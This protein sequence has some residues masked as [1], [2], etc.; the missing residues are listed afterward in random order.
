MVTRRDYTREAV[1][2]AHSVLIEIMR[3]LGEYRNHIVVVGGLV[4]EFL[5]LERDEPYVGTMDVDL[6]LD[7][8]ELQEEGYKTIEELLRGRG[9]EQSSEQPFIFRRKVPAA[10]REV[11]VQVDLLAGEYEGTGDSHRTQKVQGV[12]ARKAR[13]CDLAFDSPME[14]IIEGQLPGGGKTSVTLRVASIV[15]FLVMKG[16]ALDDRL[17]EKDAYDIYYCVRNF[18]KGLDGLVD[19]FNFYVD[20]D[21]V[22]EGLVKIKNHFASV[23]HDGPRFV[24]DFLAIV[25]SEERARV[26]RDAY[27]IVHYLLRELGM[28]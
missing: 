17:K 28:T 22:Q 16:M 6:A 15:P 9:Y 2:A 7:H 12:R 24:V 8:R 11:T 18:S 26:Q 21:L 27:E 10:G 25:D 5:P 4:P 20:N 23:E 19:E 13:G 14:T 1:E 3:V